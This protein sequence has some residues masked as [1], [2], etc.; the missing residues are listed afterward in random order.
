MALMTL[1]RFLKL[2]KNLDVFAKINKKKKLF[3]SLHKKPTAS[4]RFSFDF[5][6]QPIS[7]FR[8][9]PFYIKKYLLEYMKMHTN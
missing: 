3:P 8:L 7:I 2:K 6:K 4:H 5:G 9:G 1:A